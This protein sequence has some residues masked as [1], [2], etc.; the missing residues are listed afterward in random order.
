VKQ[1]VYVV[2]PGCYEVEYI[3]AGGDGGASADETNYGKATVFPGDELKFW[4]GEGGKGAP[5]AQNGQNAMAYINPIFK[6]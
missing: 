3:L 5:G 4:L 1:Y 2:P 6:E